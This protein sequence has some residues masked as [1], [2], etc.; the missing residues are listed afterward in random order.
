M[1]GYAAAKAQVFARQD[2]DDLAVLGQ[3]DDL[4]RA[5]RARL[6]ARCVPVSGAAAPQPGGY[7]ADAAMVLRDDGGP[8][9]D[10]R[11]APALPGRHNAQ[12]AA[13][14][15]ACAFALG[16]SRD[17]VAGGLRTYPGLPHRQERVGEIA[18]VSFVNDSKATNA[19]S[20]ARALESYDRVVWIAG[21][22][23]KAGGIAPLAPLFPRVARA[24]LIGE[25][26][27]EFARALAAAGVPHEV[28]GTLEAAV[29][30]AAA[31]AFAGAA[32]V[33]LLS[34]ACASWDQFTGFDAR[35]DRFRTLVQQLPVTT[36]PGAEGARGPHWRAA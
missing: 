28:A 9:L 12:N 31:A 21:G 4:S 15:A 20:A 23:A 34:P 2:A 14:A 13:A 25:S 8:I 30:A 11:D 26:A 27:P 24:V 33:V 1:E 29:P 6:V 10:L 35:G 17:A 3:D 36:T 5:V 19:D 18:G 7:W 32:P 16:L 22:V